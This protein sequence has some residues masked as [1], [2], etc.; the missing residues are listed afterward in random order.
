[1]RPII[2]IIE[3]NNHL[4]Q[5]LNFYLRTKQLVAWHLTG[6][7]VDGEALLEVSLEVIMCCKAIGIHIYFMTN[8]MGPENMSVF[9]ILGIGKKKT[10]LDLD[11]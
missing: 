7:S 4:F 10:F 2:K 9:K 1:M 5:F 3:H 8:D 11:F 6:S